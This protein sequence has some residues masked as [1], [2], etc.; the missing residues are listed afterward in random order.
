[1]RG[2]ALFASVMAS[3]PLWSSVNPVRLVGGPADKSNEDTDDTDVES[4]F[5]ENRKR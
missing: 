4:Y 3:T 2:G 5:T 1:M